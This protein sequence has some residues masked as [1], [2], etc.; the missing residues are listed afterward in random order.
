MRK[1]TYILLAVLILTISFEPVKNTYYEN[2]R[3]QNEQFINDY[4]EKNNII[5][6][7]LKNCQKKQDQI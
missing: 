1:I 3:I 2:K 6:M 4:L 5:I 7:Q